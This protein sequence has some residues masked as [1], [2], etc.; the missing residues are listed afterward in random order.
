MFLFCQSSIISEKKAAIANGPYKCCLTLPN[1]KIM[2]VTKLK[3]F[4]DNKLN[5][6]KMISLFCIVENTVGKGKKCWLP[7]FSPFPTM[8]SKAFFSRVVKS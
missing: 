2:D 3:E 6:G 7:A 5:I 1:K 4:A 8:F